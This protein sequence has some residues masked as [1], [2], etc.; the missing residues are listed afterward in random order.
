MCRRLRACLA[1]KRTRSVTEH[2]HHCS[3]PM[4]RS[5]AWYVAR[6]DSIS[7]GSSSLAVASSSPSAQTLNEVP[8]RGRRV[9]RTPKAE[10]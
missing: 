3:R 4:A 2:L 6:A 10:G 9:S 8:V 7:D 1:S 5:A